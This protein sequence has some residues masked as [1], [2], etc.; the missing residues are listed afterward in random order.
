[1][2]PYSVDDE[3]AVDRRRRALGM[4]PFPEH[5]ADMRERWRASNEQPPADWHARQREI[6]DWAR[7]VGWLK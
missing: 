6:E 5:I 4:T 7:Q 2:S 3:R 1:M